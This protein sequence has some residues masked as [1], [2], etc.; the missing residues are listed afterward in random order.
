M[1]KDFKLLLA[2]VAVCLSIG[3]GLVGCQSAGQQAA[4]TDTGVA[5][6]SNSAT[7][8]S[9]ASNSGASNSAAS[10][11]A[12]STA[13][14]GGDQSG[15]QSGGRPTRGTVDKV[16]DNEFSLKATSGSDSATV[17]VNAQATIRKQVAGTLSDIKQG[18]RIILR[19]ETGVDGTIAATSV[20]LVA[21][22]QPRGGQFGNQRG[23]PGAQSG[24]RGQGQG[25]PGV[26]FGTVDNVAN[27]TITVTRTGGS[28]DQNT[29]VKATVSDKTSITKTA[30]GDFKDITPGTSVVVIG[31]RGA[32]GVVVASSI[33]ILPPGAAQMR[34]QQ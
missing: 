18:E 16:G 6:T 11:F 27:G 28:A 31:P 2:G 13:R 20:Q 4:A 32:D 29:P 22:G 1:R 9:G 19:G 30:T 33:Q 7:S 8:N 17:R 26:V 14:R 21:A 34:R 12:T 23:Q 5:A 3:V 15:Q 24:P 10:N 25:R